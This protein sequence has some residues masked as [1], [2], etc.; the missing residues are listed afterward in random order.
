[1]RHRVKG[2]HLGRNIKTRHQL[3]LALAIALVKHER[4]QT[5]LAKAQFIRDDVEKLVTLAKHGLAGND[6]Q[7]VHARRIAASRL[8]NDR[9]LVAK[10]FNTLAPRY[11]NRPGGYTRMYKLG[12]RKGDA[13][14]MVLLEFVDRSTEEAADTAK[15]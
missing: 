6:G 3:A 9:E 10:L 13:A 4:I 2:K 15:K 7:A 8:N 5:T 14:E 11:A 1:M 12:P